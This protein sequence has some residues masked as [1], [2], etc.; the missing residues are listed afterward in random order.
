MV[1]RLGYTDE[2]SWLSEDCE[3]KIVTD[4]YTWKN[5]ISTAYDRSRV[6]PPP[7]LPKNFRWDE[8]LLAT[9]L[10]EVQKTTTLRILKEYNYSDSWVAMYGRVETRLPLQVVVGGRGRLMGYGF[11]H[12]SAAPAELISCEQCHH[13]LETTV[14]PWL[15]PTQ[16]P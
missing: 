14:W 6:A 5:I 11:G 2:G 10:R 4:G 1:G 16:V 12:L 9:K 7:S 13:E 15:H 8:G 3:Y